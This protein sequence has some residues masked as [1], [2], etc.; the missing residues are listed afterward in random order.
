M[1]KVT[2]RELG[3]EKGKEK[4]DETRSEGRSYSGKCR[5]EGKIKTE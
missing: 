1:E 3:M 2:A 4:E 5:G